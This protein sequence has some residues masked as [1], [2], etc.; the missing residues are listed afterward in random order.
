MRW[1][2][3]V[4]FTQSTSVILSQYQNANVVSKISILPP[5]YVCVN[6]QSCENVRK[7]LEKC[8]V[9][10]DIDLFVKEKATGSDRPQPIPY[11]NFYHP[12]DNLGGSGWY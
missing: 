9:D 11:I 3:I 8:D 1:G 2:F 6:L 7:S 5:T 4:P 12:S 10:A